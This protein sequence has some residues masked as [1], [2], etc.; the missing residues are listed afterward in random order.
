MITSKYKSWLEFYIPFDYKNMAYMSFLMEK[1]G[2]QSFSLFV[3]I[4]LLD[5]CTSY[6]THNLFYHL[7]HRTSLYYGILCYNIV[8]YWQCLKRTIAN[9]YTKIR[10]SNKSA[11]PPSF[12]TGMWWCMSMYVHTYM[13]TMEIMCFVA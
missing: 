10:D 8:C 11:Q 12:V 5:N 4:C 3:C 6:L 13:P 9:L 7:L 1:E 2:N